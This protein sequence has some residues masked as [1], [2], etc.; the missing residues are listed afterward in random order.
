LKKWSKTTLEKAKDSESWSFRLMS[1]PDKKPGTTTLSL[2]FYDVSDGKKRYLT[3]K[4]IT[5]DPSAT[6]LASEVEVSVE[7]GVKPGMKIEL[8]LARIVGDKQTDLAK[9]KLSFK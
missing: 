5:C 9:A 6:I 1:F 7:D 8:A 2:L 4:D 3:S